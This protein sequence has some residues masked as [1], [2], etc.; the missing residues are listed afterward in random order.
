MELP[1]SYCE[2]YKENN[3]CVVTLMIWVNYNIHLTLADSS[4]KTV[5]ANIQ[6]NIIGFYIFFQVTSETNTRILVS[7]VKYLFYSSHE[8]LNKS[9][10]CLTLILVIHCGAKVKKRRYTDVPTNWLHVRK[11]NEPPRFSIVLIFLL[12]L[13]CFTISRIEV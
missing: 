13:G 3:I 2:L 9:C 5:L 12:V 10:A 4:T 7:S 8:I 1:T 6:L 11:K